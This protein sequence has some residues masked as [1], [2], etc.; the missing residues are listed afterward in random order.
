MVQNL[1]GVLQSQYD[2][3]HPSH[4]LIL[5]QCLEEI[6]RFANKKLGSSILLELLTQIG[7]VDIVCKQE[8]EALFALLCILQRL[9]L[10]VGAD[11]E[12]LCTVAEQKF[13][14]Q[15]LALF[16]EGP[17]SEKIPII[18]QALHGIV[19]FNNLQFSHHLYTCFPLFSELSLHENKAIRFALFELILRSAPALGIYMVTEPSWS[20]I[21]GIE[22]SQ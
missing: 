7:I 5:V 16:A 17:T 2:F 19:E 22:I 4:I 9:Y 21:S 14:A 11:K 15:S 12:T 13:L 3:L 8:T 20:S 10:D 18:L 6:Y 1:N